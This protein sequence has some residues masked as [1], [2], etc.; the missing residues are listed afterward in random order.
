MSEW[1]YAIAG[2]Q[3]GPI[4]D[5]ELHDLAGDG[6]LR[7]DHLVWRD[8]FSDWQPAG[9][10]PGLFVGVPPVGPDEPPEARLDD[11]QPDP[12]DAENPYREPVASQPVFAAGQIRPRPVDELK[13]PLLVSGIFN[14][15]VGSIW[16]ITCLGF[17]LTIPMWILAAYELSLYRQ[18]DDLSSAELAARA[19]SL[20]VYQI[21]AGV[22]NTPTL[23]CGIILM[24]QSGKYEDLTGQ[25]A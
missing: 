22:L 18:A 13:V 1:Y 10:I 2:Q 25:Q 11:I 17:V 16:A 3:Y 23:I 12:I 4:S 20:S 21:I 6:S 19:K 24:I 9:S 5:R 8:G 7:P 15:V 14:I